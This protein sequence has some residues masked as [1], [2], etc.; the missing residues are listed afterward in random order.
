MKI[1]RLSAAMWLL[2]AMAVAQQVDPA[3][4]GMWTLNV[5]KSEFGRT[6]KPTA[7]TVNWG[8]HG[9]VFSIVRG[10]GRLYADAVATDG[11]CALVGAFSS[12]FSCKVDI[13]APRHVRFTLLQASTVRQVG[14][15]ELLSDD[16][17]QTTHRITPANGPP[18]VEKTIWERQARK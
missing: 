11:G 6:P 3:F 4:S 12:E 7:G 8:V 18:Y 1:F 9:W 10:D 2:S 16:I 13:V 5:Q 15:I 14:D 17:T